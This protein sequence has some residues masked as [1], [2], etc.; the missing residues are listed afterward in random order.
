[1]KFRRNFMTPIVH[2]L[3]ALYHA[4]LGLNIFLPSFQTN[5][6]SSKSYHSH[7]RY[8]FSTSFGKR[9]GNEKEGYKA[10]KV[11]QINKIP[12][13]PKRPHL[14]VQNLM[15]HIYVNKSKEFIFSNFIQGTLAVDKIIT[16]KNARAW[17]SMVLY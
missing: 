11:L 10:T 3:F 13:L 12:S 5:P 7:Y 14:I 8:C 9:E 16:V 15:F 4:Q 17:V 6:L 2:S 1:M